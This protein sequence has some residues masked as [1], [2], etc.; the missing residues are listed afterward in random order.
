MLNNSRTI[1]EDSVRRERPNQMEQHMCLFN[2]YSVL[3][4]VLCSGATHRLLQRA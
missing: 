1:S 2:G 3:S 4:L